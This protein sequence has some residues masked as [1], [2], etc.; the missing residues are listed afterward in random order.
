MH[1]ELKKAEIRIKLMQQLVIAHAK[2]DDMEFRQ[3]G[4]RTDTNHPSLTD[5][6]DSQD[7]N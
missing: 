4:S 5:D 2:Y 3:D 7:L 6:M 1:A